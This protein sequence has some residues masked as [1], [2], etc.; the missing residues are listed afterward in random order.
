MRGATWRCCAVVCAL[1]VS[2]VARADDVETV[3]TKDGSIFRGELVEKVVNDH[4]TIKMATGEVKRIEWDDIETKPPPP[5]RPQPEPKPEAEVVVVSFTSDDPKATLQR[6]VGS[7]DVAVDYVT[8]YGTTVAT[9]DAELSLYRDV[10]SSPCTQ[11]VSPEGRFR[12][13]GE[14]LIPT[15]SFTLSKGGPNH[16]A[17]SMSSRGKRTAGKVLT[18]YTGAPITVVGALLLLA[19]AAAQPGAPCAG[20]VDAHASLL[21]WGGIVGGV[22]AT[23]LTIGIILWAT[24]GSSATLNGETVAL[25]LP[26]HMRLGVGGL[27]F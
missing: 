24:S 10:C 9:G 27:S 25:R 17:A 21:L 7:G 18:I 3:R 14:G 13:A 20:C 16:V 11:H 4:V 8:P 22:G 2:T 26:G 12:V 19:G 23:M 6:Y 15:E 5:A 1:V